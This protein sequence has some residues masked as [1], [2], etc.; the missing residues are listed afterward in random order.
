MIPSGKRLRTCISLESTKESAGYLRVACSITCT[1]SA[2][3]KS[4]EIDSGER[5]LFEFVPIGLMLALPDGRFATIKEAP[6]NPN[7]NPNAKA[8]FL[9]NLDTLE[10]HEIRSRIFR[11]IKQAGERWFGASC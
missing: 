6:K 5:K 2:Q 7:Q 8:H 9:R 1:A 11:G 4:D 3:E 10:N